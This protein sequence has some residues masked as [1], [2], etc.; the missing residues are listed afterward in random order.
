MDKRSFDKKHT[1]LVLMYTGLFQWNYIS[2]FY[3][4]KNQ[5]KNEEIFYLL[6]QC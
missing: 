2:N 6:L 5:R 3:K 4:L 1:N